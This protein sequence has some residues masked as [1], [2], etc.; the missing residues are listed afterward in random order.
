MAARPPVAMSIPAP[1]LPLCQPARWASGWGTDPGT[2]PP[3]P[4][5]EL[6]PCPSRLSQAGTSAPSVPVLP[7]AASREPGNKV[8]AGLWAREGPSAWPSSRRAD[9][10]LVPSHLSGTRTSTDATLFRDAGTEMAGPWAALP[11]RPDHS[12][13][14]FPTTRGSPGAARNE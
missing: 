9:R 14:S 12:L 7:P 13:C 11:S 8:G 6:W 2:P 1:P 4:G 10:L 5:P 3:L